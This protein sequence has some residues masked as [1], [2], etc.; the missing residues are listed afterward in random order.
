MKITRADKMCQLLR[1]GDWTPKDLAVAANCL[2]STAQ[3][4]ITRE[5]A[6]GNVECVGKTLVKGSARKLYTW[7]GDD[8]LITMAKRAAGYLEENAKDKLGQSI[9]NH[10]RRMTS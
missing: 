6:A 7:V 3:N 9:A 4:L 1:E 2:R 8:D 10:L 5:M